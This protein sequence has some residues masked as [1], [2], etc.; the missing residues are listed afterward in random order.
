MEI[1]ETL[2]LKALGGDDLTS[3]LPGVKNL[4][5]GGPA[6]ELGRV[7]SLETRRRL[8]AFFTGSNL[9]NRLF[10]LPGLGKSL[11]GAWDPACG[12]GDLLL[13]ATR[14]LPVERT[15][16]STLR[17][18][19][20]RISGT[21]IDPDFVRAAKARLIIAA[22]TRGT[23]STRPLPLSLEDH[24]PLLRTGDGL[25]SFPLGKSVSH[26]VLNPPFGRTQA[27]L[28]CEWAQGSV[29]RAALFVAHCIST[30]P[31]GTRIAAILPDVLR[32]GTRYRRWR[33]W[34]ESRTRLASLRICGQF[35]SCA[36]VDVFI[37]YMTVLP[38]VRRS[39][40]GMGISWASRPPRAATT[41]NERFSV[42]VGA[43]VPHRDPK[44]GP[45]RSFLHAR[46]A[47]PNSS[48]RRVRERRRFQG[49][50]FDPPFLVVRRTS[51]PSDAIR[52]VAT[53]VLGKRPVAVENHLLVL[54]PCRGGI[55]RCRRALVLLKDRRTTAFL[56]RRIRCRHLT[57]HAIREIPWTP[58]SK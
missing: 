24:F 13:G 17:V 55:R 25:A 57:V 39:W 22:A 40:G 29:S 49:R 27:P 54:Q 42:H 1:L 12:A 56:N 19:S 28:S 32:T 5:D 15:L 26:I 51:S 18:W 14:A 3:D 46:T 31:A 44:A 9:R 47:K 21:D 30:A 16:E 20:A 10:S 2:A 53:I 43:V 58:R 41:L 50:T 23:K 6:I 7:L 37:G 11:E 52:A 4:L 8:G 38:Q 48:T 35:D 34:V 33:T 45:W 36:D